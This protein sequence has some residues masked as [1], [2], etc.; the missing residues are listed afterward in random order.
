M[1]LPFRASQHTAAKLDLHKSYVLLETAAASPEFKE[2]V[3][4][5]SVSR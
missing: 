3:T 5:T 1:D 4:S 2:D